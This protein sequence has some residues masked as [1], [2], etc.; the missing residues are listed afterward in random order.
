MVISANELKVGV[1]SQQTK[2]FS[3]F[4]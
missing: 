1:Q 4:M 2:T 3:I